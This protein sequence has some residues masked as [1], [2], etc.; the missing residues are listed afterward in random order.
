MDSIILEGRRNGKDWPTIMRDLPQRT[1]HDAQSRWS[2]VLKYGKPERTKV[3]QK[4]SRSSL[5]GT[6]RPLPP[7]RPLHELLSKSASTAPS[8][9]YS[10]PNLTFTDE[11]VLDLPME[12]DE[13]HPESSTDASD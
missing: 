6:Q 7:R 11:L 1:A 9:F 10:A 8:P 4:K 5:S 13:K 3:D 12:I 2:R